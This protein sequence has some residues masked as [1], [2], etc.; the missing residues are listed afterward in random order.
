MSSR[1]PTPLQPGMNGEIDGKM[2]EVLCHVLMGI[3]E[4]GE[5]WHWSEYLLRC[6]DGGAAT[7]VY[8]LTDSGPEWKIFHRFDPASPLGITAASR[9]AVGSR[10]QVDGIDA[11]VD[12]VGQSRVYAIDGN[13]PANFSVGRLDRYFN[14]RSGD[15]LLVVSWGSSEVEHYLG[16]RIRAQDV[17]TAFGITLPAPVRRAVAP[18]ARYET[19]RE[20]RD[21]GGLAKL[22]FFVMLLGVV[23]ATNLTPSCSQGDA[24]K[25]RALPSTQLS[26]TAHLTLDGKNY[27]LQETRTLELASPLHARLCRLFL[28]QAEDG[29]WR[30]LLIGAAESPEEA[31]LLEPF[32]DVALTT[33]GA[34]GNLREAQQVTLGEHRFQCREL[35]RSRWLPSTDG[36]HP[37]EEAERLRYGMLLVGENAFWLLDWS[38]ASARLCKIRPLTPA[39]LKPRR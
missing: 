38:T 29:E 34:L 2:V 21:W 25:L 22:L 39:E 8:E 24:W 23:V 20:S 11:V 1:N 6:E 14:A 32:T 35:L 19:Q 17:E 13:A 27:T 16:G 26:K 30:R 36:T 7:L 31:W 9:L 3:E 4:G 12:L 33:P 18:A 28:L 5:T 15:H 10:V 37:P